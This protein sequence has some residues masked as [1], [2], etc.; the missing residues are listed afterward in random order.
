MFLSPFLTHETDFLQNYLR[1]QP[2]VDVQ[3]I[4]LS[5]I[6]QVCLQNLFLKEGNF[7]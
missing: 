2:H 7:K 1:R 3:A 6:Q 4:K 5:F